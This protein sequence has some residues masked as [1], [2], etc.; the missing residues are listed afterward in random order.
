MTLGNPV[1]GFGV[2][3]FDFTHAGLGPS[4]SV[5]SSTTTTDLAGFTVGDL[6]D[7][8]VSAQNSQTQANETCTEFTA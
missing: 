6:Y 8:C 3:T 2:N 7:V 4:D 1:T 5:D